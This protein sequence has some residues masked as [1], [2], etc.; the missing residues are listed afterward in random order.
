MVMIATVTFMLCYEQRAIRLVHWRLAYVHLCDLRDDAVHGAPGLPGCIVR[1][2]GGPVMK[3]R[4]GWLRFIGPRSYRLRHCRS[5][6]SKRPCH[7][8][9]RKNGLTIYPVG[10]TAK[11][12]IYRY[13]GF[14]Y[15]V[16]LSGS[17]PG[18]RAED[19]PAERALRGDD[20]G[21]APVQDKRSLLVSELVNDFIW[22]K[23]LRVAV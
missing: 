10:E 13:I 11:A 17:S 15:N 19:V 6:R 9:Y 21:Y 3:S 7:N 5:P 1:A 20:G 14:V 8:F 4:A 12:R 22:F 2:R 18:L 23:L 16:L